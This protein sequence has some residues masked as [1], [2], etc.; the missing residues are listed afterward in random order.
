VAS[1]E[2]IKC[3]IEMLINIKLYILNIIFLLKS[4]K[5]INFSDIIIENFLNLVKLFKKFKN[6]YNF[7]IKIKFFQTTGILTFYR[8]LQIMNQNY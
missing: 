1:S 4:Y 3:W 5:I 8:N 2:T 6:N 7:F